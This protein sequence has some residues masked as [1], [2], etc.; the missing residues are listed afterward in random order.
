[1]NNGLGKFLSAVAYLSCLAL[2]G[3]FLIRFTNHFSHPCTA[4]SGWLWRL[5]KRRGVSHKKQHGEAGSSDFQAR[6][7]FLKD[8]WPDLRKGYKDEDIFNTGTMHKGHPQ[9]FRNF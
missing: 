9:N 3:S 1:M 4:T 8:V 2:P 7:D 5:L 6:S